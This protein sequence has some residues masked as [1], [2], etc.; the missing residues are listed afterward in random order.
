M[1]STDDA[2]QPAPSS[3]GPPFGRGNGP[4]IVP[5]SFGDPEPDDRGRSFGDYQIL[6]EIGS[7]GMST[8]HKAL[9]KSL[10][11][12][13]AIQIMTVGR[14]TT[15]A[16]VERF[17]VGPRTAI[18]L[19]HPCIVAIHEVGQC[20]G[21]PYFSMDYVE[22]RS[23]AKIARGTQL[24]AEQAARYVGAIAEA[25]EHA[26]QQGVLHRDLKPGNILIDECG[27]PRVTDFTLA[28]RLGASAGT[29]AA[30]MLVGTPAYM[31]P[32]QVRG[33]T[34]RIGRAS[35]IYSLGVVL[36][37]L[38]AGRRPF[39]GASLPNVLTQV[40]EE[41]PISPRSFN[42]TVPR[43]LETICLKCLE[44]KPARRYA[45]AGAL[46]EDLGRFLRGGP[47]LASPI[48]RIQ[49]VCRWLVASH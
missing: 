15:E 33:V 41:E 8:V 19:C 38:V 5:G 35:D 27:L 11:R 42:P 10:E 23:L 18:S 16:D 48:G 24:P 39:M 21:R 22:G 29:M 2:P 36:Y 37:E 47:I 12:V 14:L 44:K 31:S 25:V 46:A 4:T 13:V 32:E 40:L 9:N 49:R 26:H 28:T 20:E 6:E 34:H 1:A 30:G 17:L 3:G 43:D 7:S 45:T